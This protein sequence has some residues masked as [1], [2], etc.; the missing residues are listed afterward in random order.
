MRT[1][2][3]RTLLALVSVFILNPPLFA[4]PLGTAFTYQGRLNAATGPANGSYDLKFTLN[5]AATGPAQIGSALTNAA[6]PVS[7]GVFTVTL[8]FGSGV[9][10]G[11]ARWLE[12]GVRSGGSPVDFTTLT[13]RQLLTPSPYALYAPNAGTAATAN[14]ANAVAANSVA[15][16]GLQAN[17][18][19]T[20]KIADGTISASDL[21]PALASSTFW[22]LGGNT[23]TTPGA[24]YLGTADNQPFELKAN[25]VRSFRI[26]P[27]LSLDAQHHRWPL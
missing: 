8:D 10:T 13:P 25:G 5:D 9:F 19:T 26:E 2:F 14:S 3:P 21:S 17:A 11:A 6:T 7:N 15:N 18:V 4:A 16:A 1:H 22:R 12:I 27:T 23:G 24:N 20:D